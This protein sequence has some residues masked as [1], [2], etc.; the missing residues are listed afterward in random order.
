MKTMV[1]SLKERRRTSARPFLLG[2]LIIVF[3]LLK[4]YDYVRS[5]EAVR[6]GPALSHGRDVMAIETTLHIDLERTVNHWV[7]GHHALTMILVWWYQYSHVVGTM[8]VL[9][10]CYMFFPTFY[11]PARNALALTNVAAMVVFL[12]L[13]V[14]PPR[15][16]PHA[17]FIDSV[18]LAGYGTSHGGPVEAAQFAAM[19]SLHLAWALW[20]GVVLFAMLRET[21]HRA[22][23]FLY[24]AMTTLAVIAT[25][26]HYV[27]D[28]AAGVGLALATLT[29]FGFWRFVQPPAVVAVRSATVIEP[30]PAFELES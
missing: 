17:G 20:V 23:V 5:F 7:A 26:N 25:G 10:A 2:E 11:R 8:L 19:P 14:M 28:V 29:L 30:T 18:A 22:L 27:L 9:A 6:E 24:P 16:L 1:Q 15:L 4:V 3:L 12:V 13:P 21:R